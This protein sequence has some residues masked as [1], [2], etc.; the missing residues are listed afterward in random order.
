MCASTNSGDVP[1]SREPG[2]DGGQKAFPTAGATLGREMAS[3]P[4]VQLARGRRSASVKPTAIYEV[5]IVHPSVAKSHTEELPRRRDTAGPRQGS[6]V[7]VGLGCELPEGKAGSLALLG[8]LAP[9]P[10]PSKEQ[11]AQRLMKAG[12]R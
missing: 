8:S 10:G 11:K 7:H 3:A 6:G 9:R 1:A 4:Q 12:E 5:P 2:E